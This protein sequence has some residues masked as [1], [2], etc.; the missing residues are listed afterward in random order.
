MQ[1]TVLATY[2]ALASTFFCSVLLQNSSVW[3][4]GRENWTH[5]TVAVFWLLKGTQVIFM[6]CI[7]HTPY[8]YQQTL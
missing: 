5:S 6:S 1:V 2:T 7:L 8:S 4:A 3:A